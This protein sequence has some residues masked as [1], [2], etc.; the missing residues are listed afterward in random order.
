M[1]RWP[2]YKTRKTLGPTNYSITGQD[3][4]KK[5]LG[6]DLGDSTEML[7]NYPVLDVKLFTVRILN[8]FGERNNFTNNFTPYLRGS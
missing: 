4:V 8:V 5:F 7:S 6:P 2:S 1:E 3:K